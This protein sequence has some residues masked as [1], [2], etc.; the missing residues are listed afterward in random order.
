[1]K[2][3]PKQGS[4][5]ARAV[6]RAHIGSHEHDEKGGFAANPELARLAGKIG[7]NALAKK[8]G[9]E[10]FRRIGKIGGEKVKG[11]RGS[12][13]YAEIGRQGG[14]A[15]AANMAARKNDA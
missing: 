8:Y 15:R 10:F 9:L 11:E 1:M 2:R 12:E 3:G 14:N 4:P 5:G 13:F 6:A 7:G